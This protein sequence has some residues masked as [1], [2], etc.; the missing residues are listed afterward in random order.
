VK[1]LTVFLLALVLLTCLAP[2]AAA[3]TYIEGYLGNNFTVIAPNPVDLSANPAY[4]GPTKLGLEYPRSMSTAL[5]GGLKIGTWFSR[6]G[7]PH[8]DYPDWMK[9]LGFYLDLNYHEFFFLQGAGSRRMDITPSPGFL[10]FQNYKLLGNGNIMTLGFMFAFRYGFNPTEKVPF[11]KIQPYVA[12]GPAIMIT[13][14]GPSLMFQPSDQYMFFTVFNKIPR[15]FTG[16]YQ[17]LV[18][19]GLET[20]LG[21]RFMITRFLSIDTSAK[22]RYSRP[23][24]NYDLSIDGFTHHLHFAPQFNLFSIQAGVAYHF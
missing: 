1:R 6:E 3:E 13:G 24:T 18:S 17:S 8:V 4:R 7:F 21:V 9:Y 15:T 14:I 12:V 19:L 10:H 2:L 11:G 22:Y 16:S 5:T 20:E 23:S